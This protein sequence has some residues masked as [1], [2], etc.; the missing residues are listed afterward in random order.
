MSAIIQRGPELG[1]GLAERLRS[2]A[3]AI[4][5]PAAAPENDAESAMVIGLCQD[6]QGVTNPGPHRHPFGRAPA[7]LEDELAVSLERMPS[8]RGAALGE[9]FIR[10]R[11][12]AVMP[13]CCLPGW[14]ARGPRRRPP[15][16]L[17]MNIFE[18]FRPIRSRCGAVVRS[19]AGRIR[20]PAGEAQ[21]ASFLPEAMRDEAPA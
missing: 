19:A 6:P 20:C 18:P 14:S 11:A 5:S 21:A 9:A 3:Y 17:G 12:E 10:A 16:T 8:F 1:D 4:D 2:L 13:F 15:P 7:L